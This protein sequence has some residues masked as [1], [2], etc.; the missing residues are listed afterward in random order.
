MY[1]TPLDAIAIVCG[2]MAKKSP[3]INA[4]T[5]TMIFCSERN[6]DG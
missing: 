4:A 2:R 6:R 1:V 5:R 3:Q